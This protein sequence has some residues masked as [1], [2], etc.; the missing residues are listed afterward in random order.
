MTKVIPEIAALRASIK[1]LENQEIITLSTCAYI[2]Q[3]IN[4]VEIACTNLSEYIEG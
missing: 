4:E 3:L 1:T 2:L